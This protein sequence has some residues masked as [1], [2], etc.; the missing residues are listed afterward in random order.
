MNLIEVDGTSARL[1]ISAT[2]PDARPS[3]F[4]FA[5]EGVELKI[6]AGSPAAGEW[7]VSRGGVSGAATTVLHAADVVIVEGFG[8]L[9]GQSLQVWSDADGDGASDSV[10][11]T[12][13]LTAFPQPMQTEGWD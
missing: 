6:A 12:I 10:V 3:E 1:L 7:A 13:L 9:E 4:I 5:I 11:G 2:N 8:T